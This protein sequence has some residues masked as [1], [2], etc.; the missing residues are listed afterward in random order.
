MVTG[1]AEHISRPPIARPQRSFHT[2]TR[3]IR[4][5]AHLSTSTRPP[6]AA[7]A[8][9][10]ATHGHPFAFAHAS[11]STDPKLNGAGNLRIN[12]TQVLRCVVGSGFVGGG[13]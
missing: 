4:T 9:V 12:E 11:R 3:P 8:H 1:A 5:R 13:L 2:S 6:A 10:L 7:S